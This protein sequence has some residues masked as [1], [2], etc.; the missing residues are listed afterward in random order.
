M[1]ITLTIPDDLAEVYA[2]EGIAR[3]M[4]IEPVLVERL[5]K[6]VP[7]D[8]RAR[9][10][11]I[12]GRTR[13]AIEEKLGGGHV[14]GEVDL[15]QKIRRLANIRFGDHELKLSAGQM[16]EM[17]WRAGKQGRSIEGTLKPAWHYWYG[18]FF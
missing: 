10:L 3:K 13:E 4:E 12:S 7:L 15:L 14:Q 2:E 1:R 17:V 8:P 9:P 11:I 5:L 18:K 6:A 16:E